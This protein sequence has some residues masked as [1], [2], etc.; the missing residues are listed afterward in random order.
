MIERLQGKVEKVT[1]LKKY[2]EDGLDLCSLQIDFDEVKIFGDANEFMQFLGKDVLYTKRPDRIDGKTEMVVYDLVVCSTIQTV[3]AKDNIKL[4]PEGIKRTICNFE[5]KDIRFGGYYPGRV[6]LMSK[7]QFG[8]SSKA[9]WFDCTMIDANSKE[10]QVRLFT[11]NSDTDKMSALLDSY[12]GYYVTFDLES[13]KYGYQTKEIV[14]LPNEVEI[15]PEVVVAKTIL[16]D[17]INGDE[18][19]ME[20]C[21]KY[22]FLNNMVS[23][24]DGEPGYNLVRMASEIYMINAI[25]NI[26]TDLDVKAMRRA[27]ICSRGYLLPKKTAWSRPM[28]NTNKVLMI[29]SLKEDRELRLILDTMSEEESSATKRTYISIKGLVN[30]IVKIRR[31]VEDEKDSTYIDGMRDVFNG[32]L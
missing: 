31:G 21:R 17:V 6:A 11:S 22:D 10:F 14:S 12:I 8:S 13:T 23:V 16:E 30:S 25:D 4:I 5:S 24:I 18:G 27:V 2:E 15:S 29:P 3:A 1:F 20:Y 28:L 32:L 7:H 26:S 19:L 9:K